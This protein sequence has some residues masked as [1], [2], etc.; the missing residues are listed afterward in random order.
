MS[1]TIVIICVLLASLQFGSACTDGQTD[2]A[3][4]LRRGNGGDPGTLDP[5]LAED[6]HAFNVL[7][8][9]YEG[10]TT[11]S[12]EGDVAPGVAESW[13]ISDDGLKYTFKL[14]TDARWSNGEPVSATDF[15]RAF[16][17]VASPDVPSSYGFLLEPIQNF[18]DVKAG[19]LPPES[20]GVQVI[21]S[22][23]LTLT[24][25]APTSYFLSV[26]AM[27]IA[28]PVH[29][30]MAENGIFSRAEDFIGNGAYSLADA[31]VGGPILLR[32]N[33]M[34]WDAKSVHFTEIEYFPIADPNTELNMYRSGE[35]DITNTIPPNNIEQL[36]NTSP[37][38]IHIAPSLAFY[39]LAFDLTE[40][41]FDDRTLRESLSL[42]IDR[43]QLI[44][45]I[46]RGEQPAYSVV[47]PGVANHIGASYEWRDE[48][49]ATRKTRAR[50]R[51]AAAG[52]GET[53][54]LTIKLTYDVGDI[55]ERI[56]LAVGA[57]WRDVL[58]VNVELEKKEWKYFLDSRNDRATWE[59]M[60]FSWFGDY[61]DPLTFTE[62]FRS[63]SVQ[64]LSKYND[65]EFDSLVDR[66][67]VETNPDLRLD[68][69]TRAE[70]ALLEDYPIV[71]LYFYVSKHLVKPEI[72]G[73]VENVLDRH[74]SKHLSIK[75]S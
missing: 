69:M 16:R 34:Y 10:L 71:P 68:L 17:R 72:D 40:A 58:N 39:Y 74:P 63:D 4:V 15:V 22:Q 28:F 54:P 37:D 27:P 41:P 24:L 7:N 9:L 20:L 18:S 53:N 42:A 49:P 21:D 48:E 32:R 31:K 6:V 46:G 56:A 1:R 47:P 11:E 38:E 36:R 23:T 75:G 44:Q 3:E 43:N 73:F 60:R 45:I 51:Y 19:R 70:A 50:Q 65:A 35:L 55:H 64:N 2:R 57:M 29:A 52:Y 61:N 66:A 62:I 14:R 8:D 12:P 26:L 13:F 25:R 67:A 5:A 33:E 30:K 59:I